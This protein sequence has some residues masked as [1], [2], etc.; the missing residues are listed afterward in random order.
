MQAHIEYRQW[1]Q[2]NNEYENV[3]QKDR[4]NRSNYSKNTYRLSV[5]R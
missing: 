3:L 4:M 2:V 1:T 5:I